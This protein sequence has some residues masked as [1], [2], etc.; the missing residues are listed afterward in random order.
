MFFVQG[1]GENNS[2]RTIQ[3]MFGHLPTAVAGRFHFTYAE[4]SSAA[5]VQGLGSS[6]RDHDSRASA[7]RLGTAAAAVCM[8]TE[9]A[10]LT[11]WDTGEMTEQAVLPCWAS[12]AA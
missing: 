10:S 9:A 11:D 12:N 2:R 8:P 3:C 4:Q 5:D 1:F 7:T 6:C